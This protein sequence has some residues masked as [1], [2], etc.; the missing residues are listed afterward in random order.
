VKAQ[1]WVK[2]AAIGVAAACGHVCAQSPEASR[3]KSDERVVLFPTLAARNESGEWQ[4]DVRGWIY[5]P[6]HD[7]A[8]RNKLL[9]ALGHGAPPDNAEA[10]RIFEERG[11]PF[12]ADNESAKRIALLL[13]ERPFVGEPS[14]ANGH[15]K[16]SIRF[17]DS[18]ARAAGEDDPRAPLTLRVALADGDDRRFLG[19]VYRIED[20]GLSVICDIDDTV[21]ITGVGDRESLIRSTFFES[22]KPVP[23]VRAQC[24]E[25]AA[26]GAQFHYVSASPWQ[27]YEP[28]E[29]FLRDE[30]FPAG[31]FHLKAFRLKDS[32]FLSLFDNPEIHKRPIIEGLIQ[33]WPGRRFILIGDTGER[34][35]ELYGDIARRFPQQVERVYLRDLRNA[36][37][38]DPRLK[39]ALREVPAEKWV[40]I[41]APKEP[42]PTKP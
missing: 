26:A 30:G 20:S 21:R 11:R 9:E 5:E 25:L 41:T 32:T 7:S 12:V 24:S 14:G 13:G 4:A 2:L 22:F 23:E 3:V 42:A 1:R 17:T 18:D 29:R 16:A 10:R 31:S 28:L 39:E 38:R 19:L 15:F 27:L 36:R 40:L 34:D 37:R 8:W 35:P 33:R 6:E